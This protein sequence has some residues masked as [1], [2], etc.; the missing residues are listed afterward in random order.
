M[1][2]STLSD[3]GVVTPI[4]PAQRALSLFRPPP[5]A[6]F[7]GGSR[8]NGETAVIPDIYQDPRIPIEAYRPTFVKSLVMVPIRKIDPVGAIGNYWAHQR[9]PTAHEVSLLQ[10]LA[11]STSVA[12][13]N[14][15]VYTEL[16]DR[17][18]DRTEALERAN[19]EIRALSV[20]DELTGLKNRRGFYALAEAALVAARRS[21]RCSVLAFLDVDGLK[22]VNDAQGHCSGDAMLVDVAEVL[23]KTLRQ[24]DIV[25]RMGG[26]EFCVLVAEPEGGQAVLRQR[27]LGAFELFNQTYDRPYRLAASIGLVEVCPD[28]H[29]SLDRLLTRADELMYEDKKSK[30]ASRLSD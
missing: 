2:F 23:R 19:A 6:Y 13:E 28:E 15:K 8:L 26:D 9:Q 11:D 27:I 5:S 7:I 14:V 22:Q 16:E 25:A 3:C 29:H 10:A 18:R 1:P 4:I 21:R 30:P 12:I 20:T 24:S 17:F